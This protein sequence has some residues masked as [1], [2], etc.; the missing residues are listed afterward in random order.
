MYLG[1]DRKL[2]RWMG[3]DYSMPGHYFITIC[4]QSRISHFGEIVDGEMVLNEIGE[5]VKNQWL[6]LPEN[7]D[8]IKLDEWVV[9][10]NHFHGIIEIINKNYFDRD[11]VGTVRDGKIFGDINFKITG[12]GISVGNGRDRSLHNPNDPEIKPLP[13]IIGAFKTTS[14]KLIHRQ[15]ND[16]YFAWQK[17]FH[18]RVVR[19]EKELIDKRYYIRQNP[20]QWLED[21]NNP[22]NF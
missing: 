21:R 13:E 11:I 10:P 8:Y 5:I 3:Y 19:N 1:K 14:S 22:I 18:D 15:Q 6:W 20:A 2:N 12:N 9:M 4:T 16:L 17:S 7:F